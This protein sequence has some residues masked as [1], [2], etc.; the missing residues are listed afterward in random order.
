MR[1]FL[2]DPLVP[3]FH[4]RD[5]CPLA[6]LNIHIGVLSL[7]RPHRVNA[8][9]EFLRGLNLNKILDDVTRSSFKAVARPAE[10][11]DSSSP[12]SDN[13]VCEIDSGPYPP[14]P[15]LTVKINKLFTANKESFAAPNQSLDFS[16][17]QN[18]STNVIDPSSRIEAFRLALRHMWN[19]A[20]FLDSFEPH[21]TLFL[22]RQILKLKGNMAS[23]SPEDSLKVEM[24]KKSWRTID[25]KY[26]DFEWTEEFQ[27]ERLCI[28]RCDFTPKRALDPLLGRRYDIMSVPLPG[29]KEDMAQIDGIRGDLTFA[30]LAT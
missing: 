5:F 1:T 13:G 30:D 18:L 16:K 26:K 6:N 3:E 12:T 28:I 24:L 8:A 25:A 11:V 9:V 27:L 19:D 21:K 4:Q 10:P 22:S 7:E 29:A 2:N 15:P 17:G 14:T 20:G 23:S